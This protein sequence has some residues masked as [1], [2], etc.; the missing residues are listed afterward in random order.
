MTH[1]SL[2]TAHGQ[3]AQSIQHA[4]DQW[5]KDGTYDGRD[6]PTLARV[7]VAAL[8][9]LPGG[10]AELRRRAELVEADCGPGSAY[11]EALAEVRELAPTADAPDPVALARMKPT[12]RRWR[13]IVTAEPL[14]AAELHDVATAAELLMGDL[15]AG[16]PAREPLERLRLACLEVHDRAAALASDGAIYLHHLHAAEGPNPPERSRVVRAALS[17]P[18]TL[19]LVRDDL[20]RAAEALLAWARDQQQRVSTKRSKRTKHNRRAPAHRPLTDKQVKAMQTVA[21][22]NGSIAE[23]ARRL[24]KDRSTVAQHYRTALKKLGRMAS[25]VK[26]KTGALPSDKRGQLTVARNDA[27]PSKLE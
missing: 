12:A 11:A 15:T 4:R 22:C 16:D 21:E 14:T 2:A 9:S 13:S 17:D 8:R 23:A 18:M 26:A 6:I 24:G 3:L 25:T 5:Q 27:P 20:G 7:F 10:A 1:E 19:A